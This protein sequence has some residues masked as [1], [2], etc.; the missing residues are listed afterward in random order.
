[1]SKK[2]IAAAQPRKCTKQTRQAS[3]PSN[4]HTPTLRKN[5]PVRTGY[6]FVAGLM[7]R[8]ADASLAR[9]WLLR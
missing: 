8:G 3:A 1:M 6:C 7:R 2:Q 4:K 5:G 9:W